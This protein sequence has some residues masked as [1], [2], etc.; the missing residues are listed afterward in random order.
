MNVRRVV[1]A[2]ASLLLLTL[3]VPAFASP[4]IV[5]LSYVAGDVRIDRNKAAGVEQA[6]L[7]MPV[8]E[9]TRIYTVGD[10]ARVEI[11]FENGST[12]RMVGNGELAFRQLGSIDNGDKQSVVDMVKGTTYFDVK[13][14]NGDDFRVMLHDRDVTVR[15]NSHFRIQLEEPETT[16]AVFN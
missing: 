1:L 5:R 13:N 10:D 15:K 2:L 9:G 7:N 12:M 4:R 14:H 11:E 8:V 6:I 16:V 3:S